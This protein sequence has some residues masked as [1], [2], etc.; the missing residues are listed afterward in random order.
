MADRESVAQ[1]QKNVD[2][3][4]ADIAA[5]DG[6]RTAAQMRDEITRR[7]SASSGDADLERALRPL[8]P[9]ARAYARQYANAI[10]ALEPFGVTPQQI[11][12]GLLGVADTAVDQ[13]FRASLRKASVDAI[14]NRP[15]AEMPAVLRTLIAAQPN[16]SSRGALFH[17]FREASMP[18]GLRV[19][20][21][22]ESGVTIAHSARRAD[23]VVEVFGPTGVFGPTETG[24]YLGEDKAGPGAFDRDQAVHYSD[25]IREGKIRTADGKQHL[26]VLYFFDSHDHALAA[27]TFMDDNN[28]SPRLRVAYYDANGAV[29]WLR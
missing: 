22:P 12:A 29:R 16:N 13:A 4:N 18:T 7:F 24:S 23:G 15:Q 20:D 14:R 5:L 9:Y 28:L 21:P 6:T 3:A 11:V 27:R 8:T 10:A 17:E 26:G 25:N 2:A 1:A 19:I